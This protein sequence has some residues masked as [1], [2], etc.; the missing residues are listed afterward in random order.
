VD[1]WRRRISLKV[2]DV[3]GLIEVSKFESGD[4]N[5]R[6]IQQRTGD[7]QMIFIL[8]LA[9]ARQ[10]RDVTEPHGVRTA[11]VELDSAIATA[12]EAVETRA[13]DG[14]APA[15]SELE[16]TL[17]AFEHAMTGTEALEKEGTA[18]LAG[19]LALY[20]TL[21]ATIKRLSACHRLMGMEP[22]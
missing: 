17:Q 2:A 3:Q 9:L 20:R 15:V 10:G 7:A 21:V 18:H 6:E 22:H 14:S 19:R 8:L 1:A 11:V 4:F 12:L 13:A 5:L 16:E